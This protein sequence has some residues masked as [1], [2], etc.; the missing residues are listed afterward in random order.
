M[1]HKLKIGLFVFF[2][3]FLNVCLGEAV[4]AQTE[5]VKKAA[6]D[7]LAQNVSNQEGPSETSSQNTNLPNIEQKIPDK[8]ETMKNNPQQAT[9]TTWL[10]G[11]GTGNSSRIGVQ[12]AAPLT[13]SLDDAIR[14]ALENNNDVSI[15]RDD[16]R[17]QE[18]QIRSLRGLYDPVFN[19]SPN[20]SRNSRTNQSPTNDFNVNSSFVQQ[21]RTGGNYNV[22]FNNT[23]TENAFSQAEVSNG[24][25]TGSSSAVYS[26]SLGVR[27]VQPLWRNR[28]I[29]NNRRNLKIARRRLEQTDADFRRITIETIARV[30]NAYWDLVFA[31]R[32]QQNKV[33]NRDLALE[34]LKQTEARIAAGVSA[35]LAK[36]EVA[37]E[38]ANREADVLLAAQQV[39][40]AENNLKQ[41]IIREAESAEWLQPIVPTDRPVFSTTPV[42]LNAAIKDA[43]ENRYELK[44]LKLASDINKIDID[45]FKNQTRPQ[46]DFNTTFSLD[47]LSLGNVNT[48]PS[49]FPL[50]SSDPAAANT[51]A[52]AFLLSELRRLNP[53]AVINVPNIT[54]PG[55]PS[56]LAGGFNRSL[57]N[58]FRSDAPNVSVGVTI[59][60]PLR[61][62]TAEANL[63]GAQITENQIQTQ[64]RQQEQAILVEVRNAVQAVETARQ[65]VIAARTARENAEIQLD[66]ERKLYQAGRSTTF[67]LFQR[68]NAL[69]NARNAEIRAE[70]DYNKALANLQK[71]TSTTFIVNKI[72]VTSP[73]DNK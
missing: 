29:D 47:G 10:S 18:T 28:S 34:N 60:L 27:F 5:P 13:L 22:F 6:D 53:S 50:I 41:L 57:S 15:A 73:I 70:T 67:L 54:V 63:A 32:D 52:S 33:A 38:L 14:R 39:S 20:Y 36:A 24:S 23:R 68:E 69:A 56:F 19:V 64:I 21:L 58:M 62:R 71:A 59:S 4:S 35:P 8:P 3:L 51:N 72:E 40:I 11:N 42:D 44:R 37:T 12:S 65:R 26:S 30:Q 1:L 45:F 61:N 31:L 2:A 25:I 66:G 49:T 7:A 9:S 17:F 16:V 48:A 46:I 55:T 43:M